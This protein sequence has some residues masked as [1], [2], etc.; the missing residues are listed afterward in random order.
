MK[1]LVLE[2]KGGKVIVLLPGGEM[3]TMRARKDWEVGMEVPVRPY[4]LR[5]SGKTGIRS[6][7]YPLAVCAA[8]FLV[9]FTGL[10]L[11]GGNHIDRQHPI[12]PLSSGNPSALLTETPT[13]APTDAPTSVPT[14]KPTA[15]PVICDECGRTGHDDDDCP[16]EKCDECGRTGHDDDDCPYEKCDECGLSGHD[17]DD[18]PYHQEDDD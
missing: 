5:H 13:I 4:P 8:A 12:G 11:L 14:E 17:D 16:Y 15:K 1:A 6:V 7:L 18:C 10:K 3:R 9:V 2:R